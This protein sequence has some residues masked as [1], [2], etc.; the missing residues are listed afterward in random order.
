MNTVSSN[1]VCSSTVCSKR[2]WKLLFC[3]CSLGWMLTSSAF[4]ATQTI[5]YVALVDGGKNAGH[6]MV[7]TGDDGVTHVDFIF[8]DN[9]RGPELK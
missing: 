2:T 9:G 8:K 3:G 4:A 7:T 5:Q 6:Q 1:T